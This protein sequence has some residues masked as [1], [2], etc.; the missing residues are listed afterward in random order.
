MVPV[1]QLL[2]WRFLATIAALVLLA[3]GVDAV[4]TGADKEGAIDLGGPRQVD[5]DGNVT[6]RKIDLIAP[7]QR[8]ERS[9]DFAVTGDGTTVGDLDA[10]LDENRVMHVAPGTPGQISCEALDEENA[11]VVLADVL[12]EAV[13]WF[14]VLPRGPAGTVEL[15]PIVELQDGYAL[16]DN[17]WQVLYETVIDRERGC[18]NADIPSFRDFLRRFGPDSITQVDLET[19]KVAYVVCRDEF[20]APPTTEADDE[21]GPTGAIDPGA[22]DA[23]SSDAD[24]VVDPAD[25]GDDAEAEELDAET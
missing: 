11:C 8:L 3:V 19:Q 10:V 24:P 4:V 23:P 6:E 22:V 25:P 15:P 1:R 18:P 2:N 5:D 12:G 21:D 20:V 16:F 7:A 13:V 14:A 17:G 9:D